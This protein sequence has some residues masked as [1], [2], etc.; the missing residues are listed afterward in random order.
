[1]DDID[2]KT[3]RPL[4]KAAYTCSAKCYDDSKSPQDVVS[5][6]VNQ[7]QLKSEAAQQVY[8]QHMAAFQDRLSR[9][10]QTCQDQARNSLPALM[11]SEADGKKAEQLY[12]ACV[13][14]VASEY[15]QQVPKLYQQVR[16]GGSFM[17][18]L[19]YKFLNLLRMYVNY[20]SESELAIDI[21]VIAYEFT[22][23]IQHNE[24]VFYLLIDRSFRTLA[25]S[26]SATN[27][28]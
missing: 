28:I 1:M 11:P 19:I 12:Y 3:F 23:N 17:L 26:S 2:K 9:A 4:A 16:G 7:C 22:L 18:Q 25:R 5:Q 6:C 27:Y 20:T 21:D 13:G 15:E 10:M 14:R 24:H 8:S